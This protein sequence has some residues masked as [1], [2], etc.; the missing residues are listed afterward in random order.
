MA[1]R[2]PAFHHRR[3]WLAKTLVRSGLLL[4]PPFG[5]GIHKWFARMAAHR[6]GTAILPLRSTDAKWFTA[7]I[8]QAAS[9]ML[10]LAGRV[11]FYKPDGTEGGSCP[12]ATMIV[13]HGADNARR[14]LE[15]TNS[16]HDIRRRAKYVSLVDKRA[17]VTEAGLS[18]RSAPAESAPHRQDAICSNTCAVAALLQ[19][20]GQLGTCLGLSGIEVQDT[21]KTQFHD[22]GQQ[23]CLD[24]R[25]MRHGPGTVPWSCHQAGRRRRG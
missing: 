19:S 12:H 6:N 21:A 9:A 23:L 1:D 20:G 16:H 11:K 4:N 13:A 5:G 24:V 14:L 8:W 15:A 10:F 18:G 2:H 22:T 3:R 7:Y 17:A 25:I